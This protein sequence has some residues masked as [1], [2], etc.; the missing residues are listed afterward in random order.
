M[1]LRKMTMTDADKML[2]WK[3][4]S[5]TRQFAIVAKE[6]IKKEDHLAWLKDNIQYFQVI[7]LSVE[8]GEPCGAVRIKDNEI[9]IWIDR[10]FWGKGVASYILDEVSEV[11]MTAKIVEGNVGSMRAFIKADF[12]PISYHKNY[13]IFQR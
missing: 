12:K 9:S 11:G 4:Y 1:I 3:N 8:T 7:E 13:Y 10:K 5:E 6:E 2:E